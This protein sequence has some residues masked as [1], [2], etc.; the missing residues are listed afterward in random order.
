MV[1]VN[2][3]GL[4]KYLVLVFILWIIISK[5]KGDMNFHKTQSTFPKDE[6][7]FTKTE[8]TFWKYTLL[9]IAL[10]FL[11]S[12]PAFLFNAGENYKTVL[13]IVL[14][15]YFISTYYIWRLIRKQKEPP[16]NEIVF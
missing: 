8:E 5:N 6:P 7:I 10:G 3:V 16:E 9:W 2:W 11:F 1:A 12:I 15:G 13:F 4:V 14:V